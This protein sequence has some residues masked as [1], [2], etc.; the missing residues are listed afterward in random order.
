M[1][2]F[3][4]IRFALALALLAAAV[5]SVPARAACDAAPPLADAIA[6]ADIVFVGTVADV[7]RRD[8]TATFAVEEVW[9]G[10]R[11]PAVVTVHGSSD[12]A[13]AANDDRAWRLGGRYLVTATDDDG[14]LR[15]NA[16][17][18]SRPWTDALAALR[19]A[20]AHPP[21]DETPTSGPPGDPPYAL[22]FLLIVA[23]GALGAFLLLR[24]R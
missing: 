20:D 10:D 16:C 9:R 23:G 2:M 19:P 11:L 24:H 7:S 21:V 4:R 18:A 12:T 17:S 15:D 6:A 1:S 22:V 8:S 13:V 5:M 14:T 3:Q